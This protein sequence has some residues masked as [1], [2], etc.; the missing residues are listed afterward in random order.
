M[1]AYSTDLRQRVLAKVDEGKM[2]HWDIALLFQ[3]SPSWIRGLLQ[4]RREGKSLIP[5]PRSGGKE[6]TMD[7]SADQTLRELVAQKSDATLDELRLRLS[8]AGGPAVS[9]ATIF[10]SLKRQNVTLKKSR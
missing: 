6:R 3:V 1:E 9:R 5:K 10:R 8:Q 7:A 2:T 4:K